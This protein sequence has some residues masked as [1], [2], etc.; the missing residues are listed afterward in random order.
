MRPANLNPIKRSVFARVMAIALCLAVVAF[1]TAMVMHHHGPGVD[2]DHATHC[3]VC[4]L[5]HTTATIAAIVDLLVM[6]HVLL[7]IGANAPTRGSPQ[8]LALP[9]TRPPPAFR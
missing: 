1:F 8:L 4:A 6:M 5:G 9:T 3:Q 7:L 2:G